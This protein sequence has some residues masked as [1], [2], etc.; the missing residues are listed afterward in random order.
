VV[1][2]HLPKVDWELQGNSISPTDFIG[3]TNDEDVNFKTNN[4]PRLIIKKDGTL[5]LEL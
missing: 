5:G 2:T 4:L 1:L 3:S